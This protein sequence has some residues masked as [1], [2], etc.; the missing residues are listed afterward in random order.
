[1][2]GAVTDVLPVQHSLRKQPFTSQPSA[3]GRPQTTHDTP[4]LSGLLLS[5]LLLSTARPH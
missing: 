2:R 1:M 4:E 5:E 3:G